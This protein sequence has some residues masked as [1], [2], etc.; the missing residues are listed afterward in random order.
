MRPFL[1]ERQEPNV[2]VADE[3]GLDRHLGKE[4]D[5]LAAGHHLYQG[6]EAGAL[7][8]GRPGDVLEVAGRKG[9]VPH[10]VALFQQQQLVGGQLDRGDGPRL[11]EGVTRGDGDDEVLLPEHPRLHLP[12]VVGEGEH[13]RVQVPAGQ[14]VQQPRRLLLDQVD[15]QFGVLRTNARQYAG[16]HEGADGRYHADPQGA[17]QGALVGL[18]PLH[19]FGALAEDLGGQPGDLES[20]GGRDHLAL[21]PLEELKREQPLEFA[22]AG[23]EGGLGDEAA[24]GGASEVA[25]FGDGHQVLQLPQ[26]GKNHRGP[27]R[28]GPVDE[29]TGSA[30]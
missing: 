8:G 1:L 11:G 30:P 5:P 28:G 18:G 20:P 4:G 29:S 14:S 13:G 27:L 6:V 25:Q 24:F 7:K 16:Q 15:P 23:A 3:V 21:G 19:Q 2:R 22:N 9:V 12:G 10:A 17:A 26:R